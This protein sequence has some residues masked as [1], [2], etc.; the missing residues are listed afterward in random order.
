VPRITGANNLSFQ[1]IHRSKQASSAITFVV[2][3]EIVGYAMGERMS[4]NLISQSLL[5][6]LSTRR[7]EKG[8]LHHFDRG[9]QYRSYDYQ[10]L[11]E[12]YGME[13]SMSGSGNC[14]DNDSMERF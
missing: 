9:S 14:Y 8:L 13:A 4:R 11:M 1:N 3:G 2:N 7:P 10:N 5:R 12:N 6:A